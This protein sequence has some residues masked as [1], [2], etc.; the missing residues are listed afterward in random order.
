MDAKARLAAEEAIRALS[1]EDA[2]GA[3]NAISEAYDLDH[4]LGGLADLVHLACSEIE[5]SDR[6]STATWNALADAVAHD[7]LLAVV[8][9]S[10]SS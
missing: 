7:E 5:S 1:R 10:R 2:P 9:G 4:A 6:V 8:E 3:R